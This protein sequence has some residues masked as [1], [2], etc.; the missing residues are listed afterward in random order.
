MIIA[1]PEKLGE[2]EAG[3]EERRTV[4]EVAEDVALLNGEHGGGTIGTQLDETK[5]NAPRTTR[6]SRRRHLLRFA[7]LFLILCLLEAYLAR[8]RIQDLEFLNALV[9]NPDH[10][11]AG[12]DVGHVILNTTKSESLFL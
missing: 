3:H 6:S 2:P 10:P 1:D 9:L 4:E 12:L 7:Y 11:E 8:R 5:V